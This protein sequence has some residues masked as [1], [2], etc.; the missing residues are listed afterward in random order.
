MIL[1][2]GGTGFLGSAIVREL[3]G[4]GEPVAVLGRDASRIRRQFGDS[5][6]AREADVTRPGGVLDA[7]MRGIDVAVDCVQFPNYPIENKAKGWTFEEV[8]LKGAINQVDAG[9]KAGVR[10]YVYLSGVGA[11]PD[12]EQHWFRY[13]WQAER[14]LRESGLEWVVIR[15]T[16]V[17]GPNDNSLNRILRFGDFMPVIPTFGSGK[18]P[19]QPV[20]VDD[21]AGVA[22]DAALK[23]EAANK[24]FELGG[25]EV[26]TMD[27][28]Y[29]TALEVQGRKRPIL[30]QP[31]F[32]GKAMGTI[33]SALP[34]AKRM[35]SADAI[36]FIVNPAV[37]DN[38]EVEAVLKPK[39]TPLRE[40]LATY[41]GKK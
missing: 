12:A 40:G 34:V 9:R 17:Y 7:A 30:H 24:L 18:Q 36:D 16:W 28:V 2:S 22:A 32:A 13:K 37:A 25:P 27:D 31:V 4:R 10:R 39:R 29:K 38:R 21:V 41:L 1:V 23:P 3:L 15:P 26:M 14:H 35:L 5:V 6:E 33:A 20:F 8:D 19:M 11:S